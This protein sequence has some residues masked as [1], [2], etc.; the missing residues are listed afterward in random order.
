ME[1][2]HEE[3]RK[4]MFDSDGKMEKLIRAV[5]IKFEHMPDH[6][7]KY[8]CF[9]QNHISA[10]EGD[11]L[12]FSS[13]HDFNDIMESNLYITK[14]AVERIHQH[15]YDSLRIKYGLPK[16]EI[17][18]IEALQDVVEKLYKEES[19]DKGPH[20]SR[21][22]RQI[23]DASLEKLA[24][25]HY[26]MVEAYRSDQR[27]T[28]S[29]CCFS[30]TKDSSQMWGLYADSNQGFCVQYDFKA[31]GIDSCYTTYL[32][33]VLYVEDTRIPVDD[34]EMINGNINMNAVTLKEKC[35]SYEKEWRMVY[36]LSVA[37]KPVRMPC[38]SAIYLGEKASEKNIDRMRCFCK[39]RDINLY[40][41]HYHQK[42]DKIEPAQIT[43]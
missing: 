14:K 9:T 31:L 16:E 28:Y 27:N 6:L 1:D 23:L 30:E 2:W 12:Y 43:L 26:K 21:K 13:I 39:K 32:F 5:N 38:P 42:T 24:D 17:V 33:P 3:Y 19:K 41:M 4:L 40:Q 8:R 7:Y 29:V 22:E 25:I 35:W 15:M 10:L 36:N 18:S 37:G 34:V 20:R 11:V